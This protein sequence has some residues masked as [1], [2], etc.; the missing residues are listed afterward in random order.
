MS[1]LKGTKLKLVQPIIT[2]PS[3]TP[4]DQV[5]SSKSPVTPNKGDQSG[6]TVPKGHTISQPINRKISLQNLIGVFGY[7]V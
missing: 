2:P 5:D 4:V 6:G 7:R 1:A 3:P